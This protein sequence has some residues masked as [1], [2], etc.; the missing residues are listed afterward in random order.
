LG[1]KEFDR[2]LKIVR[3]YC[4]DTSF[5]ED[6]LKEAFD[7]PSYHL[8]WQEILFDYSKDSNPYKDD[9]AANFKNAI[10]AGFCETEWKNQGL[11]WNYDHLSKFAAYMVYRVRSSIAHF[12]LGEFL[13]SSEDEAFVAEVAEPILR[14]IVLAAYTHP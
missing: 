2:L 10:T 6:L 12:R 11:T 7:Q 13:L 8:K 3:R 9:K 1:D 4:T 5:F 14:K